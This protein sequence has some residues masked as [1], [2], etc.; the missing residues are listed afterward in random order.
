MSVIIKHMIH[1]TCVDLNP[2]NNYMKVKVIILSHII[3]KHI[4][5]TMNIQ[6]T[7]EEMMDNKLR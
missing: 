2:T 4:L 3:H 1:G 7:E 5:E 6:N